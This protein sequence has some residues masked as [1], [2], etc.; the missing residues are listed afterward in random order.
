VASP[1]AHGMTPPL[2]EPDA[3]AEG[4]RRAN[5]AR[6]SGGA[7]EA[8]R[9]YR[10]LQSICPGSKEEVSSRVLV[11]RLY[12][13]R[14]AD[15]RSALAA[16]DSY[17][18]AGAGGPLREEALIGRALALGKLNRSREEQ[19]AWTALLTAYPDSIYAEKA[20]ARLNELR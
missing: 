4:F 11:G 10:T 15:P 17:L 5:Q 3:C 18:A 13:D 19:A 6:R 12:L 1:R 8:I 20:K 9:L 2:T 7:D 14:V 16:F